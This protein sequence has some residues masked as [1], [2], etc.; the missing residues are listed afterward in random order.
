MSKPFHIDDRK[1]CA[2]FVQRF[3]PEIHSDLDRALDRVR[4]ARVSD[5]DLDAKWRALRAKQ[6][7]ELD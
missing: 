1:A 7:Q 3:P 2:E 6:N 5:A 4:A